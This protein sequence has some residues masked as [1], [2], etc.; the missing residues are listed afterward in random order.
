MGTRITMN[1]KPPK[2]NVNLLLK[3]CHDIE[4]K[5][6]AELSDIFMCCNENKLNATYLR[7]N[8]FQFMSRMIPQ[9]LMGRKPMTFPEP[10][11]LCREDIVRFRGQNNNTQTPFVIPAR[12]CDRELF[13]ASTKRKTTASFSTTSC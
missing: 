4:M 10:I 8:Q 6:L 3:L 9:E 11:D 1:H 7:D 5:T 13:F 12:A 2:K